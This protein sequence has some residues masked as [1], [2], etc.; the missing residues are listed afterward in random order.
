M[1]LFNALI[2]RYSIQLRAEENKRNGQYKT[3]KTARRQDQQQKAAP[4]AEARANPTQTTAPAAAVSAA[5]AAGGSGSA[6]KGS[7]G[8]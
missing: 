3:Q 6:R 1:T 8:R 4:A 2:G 5:A 7:T